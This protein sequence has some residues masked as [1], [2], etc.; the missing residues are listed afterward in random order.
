MLPVVLGNVLG[1]LVFL[2]G[3]F[4]LWLFSIRGDSFPNF[5][6]IYLSSLCGIPTVCS[7][8]LMF[9]VH[10]FID[11][12]VEI[13]FTCFPLLN[14]IK[15]RLF[16][17]K[18]LSKNYFPKDWKIQFKLN[19]QFGR[20]HLQFGW[21]KNNWFQD[22]P[23]KLSLDWGKWLSLLQGM[24]LLSKHIKT[25][26]YEKHSPL[27]L[28]WNFQWNKHAGNVDILLKELPAKN[29]LSQV[30]LWRVGFWKVRTD[31]IILQKVNRSYPCKAQ[32]TRAKTIANPRRLF[33]V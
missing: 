25:G 22:V 17:E 19:L 23:Y 32:E 26:F 11:L 16:K 5:K 24:N 15:N 13:E 21:L 10:H 29:D 33:I 14:I 3:P 9:R 6:C 4:A 28:S 27:S 18:L 8:Q 31:T 7:S 1:S 20:N 12:T 2:G 30:Q